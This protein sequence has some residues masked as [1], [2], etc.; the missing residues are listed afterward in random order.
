MYDE[1]RNLI[2]RKKKFNFTN[3]QIYDVT[4]RDG[5]QTP[6]IAFSAHEKVKIAK[7]LNQLKIKYI[8]A[9]FPASSQEDQ[10]AVKKI[11]DL[12]LD[13]DVYALARLSKED[14][15]LA[16]ECGVRH[17]V[18]FSPSSDYLL[19]ANLKTNIDER[20]EKLKIIIDYAKRKGMYVRFGCEDASRTDYERLIRVYDA[21]YQSGADMVAF[22]DTMGMMTP[23]SMYEVISNLKKDIEI[24][25]AAHCHNDFGVGLANVLSAIEAGVDQVHVSINGLGERT[26]NVSLEELVMCLLIQYDCDMGIETKK[27]YEVSREIY[28]FAGLDIPFNKPIVGK[29]AFT[30]ESGLHVN[31]ILSSP[32]T[33]QPFPAEIIGRENEIALGKHSG[34]SSIK[35]FAEKN[36]VT[37]ISDKKIDE[38][39][40]KIKKLSTEKQLITE[41]LLLEILK[42][43]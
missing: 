32:N 28:D 20:I 13:F 12:N 40:N 15:D 22:A 36:N 8:E 31:G 16:Y 25:L 37:N 10:E 2:N 1:F 18:L 19:E 14:V 4:L 26:G 5:E 17:L 41:N 23:L 30:H 34:R 11:I 43:K 38:A 6:R 27:I 24:P 33:Y 29:N 3:L 21:C 7:F 39:L 42:E 35:Y 9:G